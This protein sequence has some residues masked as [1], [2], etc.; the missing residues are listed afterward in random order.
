MAHGT[1]LSA[2]CQPSAQGGLGEDGYMCCEGLS[3]SAVRLRLLQH[4]SWAIP[5]YKI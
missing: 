2:V 3:P 1:L 5:R 4:C